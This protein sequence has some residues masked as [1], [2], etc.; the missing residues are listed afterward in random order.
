MK[1][2]NVTLMPGLKNWTKRK[3]RKIVES[4]R[5]AIADASQRD[6]ICTAVVRKQMGEIRMVQDIGMY[7]F[8]WCNRL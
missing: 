4:S 6:H 7:R 5:G 3:M 1:P 8:Q 2:V